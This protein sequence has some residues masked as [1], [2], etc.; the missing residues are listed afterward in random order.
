MAIS[1][2]SNLQ[3]KHDTADLSIVNDS[4]C[5]PLNT[6]P[7]GSYGC[8]ELAVRNRS[9]SWSNKWITKPIHGINACRQPWYCPFVTGQREIDKSSR[10]WRKWWINSTSVFPI[11]SILVLE[12]L[13]LKCKFYSINNALLANMIWYMCFSIDIGNIHCNCLTYRSHFY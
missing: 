7:L 10:K 1:H 13:L 8:N 11:D 3:N 4:I 6:V 12:T 9:L 5:P 2:I